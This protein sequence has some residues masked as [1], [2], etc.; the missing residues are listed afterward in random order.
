[1]NFYYVNEANTNTEYGTSQVLSSNLYFANSNNDSTSD[2]SLTHKTPLKG[3]ET[4]S[5]KSVPN[6]TIGLLTPLEKIMENVE[7]NSSGKNIDTMTQYQKIKVESFK[8][9]ILQNLRN[10]IKEIL[11]GEFT[12][13]KSKC[14]E[15]VQTSSVRYNKQI[16]HLKIELKTKDKLID[17]LLES[18]SSL[19]NSELESKNTI[20]HK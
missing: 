7:T 10:N 8:E 5:T 2:S 6:L 1:M 17:H 15:Q 4:P 20:I 11:D 12:I 18:L 16:D 19:T 13:L 9:T 3:S 14:E